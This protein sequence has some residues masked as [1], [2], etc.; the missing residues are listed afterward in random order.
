M[1][2]QASPSL[3]FEHLTFNLKHPILAELA[4]RQAIATAIDTQQLVDRLARPVNPDAQVARQP[5]LAHRPAALPGPQRRLRQGQ[6][7]SRQTAAGAGRLDPWRRRGLRQGR[8]A[9]GAALRD[10]HRRPTAQG[11]RRTAPGPA[12]QGRHPAE[13][14]QHHHRHPVREW[15]GRGQ[16]RHRQLLLARQPIRDLR[17]PGHLPARRW[18]QLRQVHRPHRR[19]PVPTSHRRAGPGPGR[20]HRQPDRPAAL[21]P[22]PL[23]PALPGAQLPRLAPR[24]AQ[25]REQPDHREPCSGTP[26]AGGTPNH[27]PPDTGDE[28]ARWVL[29]ASLALP[30]PTGGAPQQNAF[31]NRCA[32]RTRSPLAPRS[33]RNRLGTAVRSA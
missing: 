29:E 16:L 26:A 27:E 33:T 2:S 21:D 13:P 32:G 18:R 1:R 28:A 7:P 22:A 5:D 6:H 4:V 9:A 17:Q 30:A 8:R 23:D 14:A 15:V 12:R 20:R 19:R 31:V 3:G 25:R 24:P 10:L 11:P